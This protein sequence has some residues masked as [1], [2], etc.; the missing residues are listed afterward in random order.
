MGMGCEAPEKRLS[1]YDFQIIPFL[2]KAR[3]ERERERE[4]ESDPHKRHLMK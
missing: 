1:R 2:S 3:R 4:R